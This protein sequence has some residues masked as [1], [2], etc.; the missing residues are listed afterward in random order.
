MN[1]N[2]LRIL[3]NGLF[4]HSNCYVFIAIHGF[5]ILIQNVDYK[6][7]HKF[8]YRSF[9]LTEYYLILNFYIYK[10]NKPKYSK[11]CIS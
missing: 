1:K 4:Y 3:T 6:G 10:N 11:N 2:Q 7:G 5:F 8:I 9:D